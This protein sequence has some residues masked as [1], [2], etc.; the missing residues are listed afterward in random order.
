MKVLSSVLM[1]CLATLP[2]A[3]PAGAQAQPPAKTVLVEGFR[4]AKF[5]MT[6]AAALYQLT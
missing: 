4:S 6:E 2:A 5:G 3:L 1:I